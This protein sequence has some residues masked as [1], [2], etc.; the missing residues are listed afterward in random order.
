MNNTIKMLAV[1][2][3]ILAIRSE[4]ATNYYSVHGSI[5]HS[6]TPGVM[7]EVAQHGLGNN[8]S[9]QALTVACPIT[10]P[11]RNYTEGYLS[12]SGYDRSANDYLS[13]TM[14]FADDTGNSYNTATS[15]TTGSSNYDIRYGNGVRVS[16]TATGSMMWI[17]CRIPPT[18]N[19]WMSVL[20]SVYATMTY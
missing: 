4:A 3:G 6:I 17:T 19:G 16:P 20:T 11:Y 5:C 8:S 9:T 15:K 13:C 18:Y 12:L 2:A 7:G 14:N 1:A 10:V